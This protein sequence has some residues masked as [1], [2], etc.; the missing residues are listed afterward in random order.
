MKCV[1]FKEFKQ[2]AGVDLLGQAQKPS[3]SFSE[4][5]GDG[6]AW[7]RRACVGGFTFERVCVM[8]DMMDREEDACSTSHSNEDLHVNETLTARIEVTNPNLKKCIATI[9]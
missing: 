2:Q 6:G 7:W 8:C 5:D 1:P 3:G 4:Q 9:I